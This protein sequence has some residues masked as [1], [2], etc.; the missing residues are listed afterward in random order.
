M[1]RANHVADTIK[2]ALKHVV[3]L[4]K[5][6][7]TYLPPILSDLVDHIVTTSNHVVANGDNNAPE[8]E[9]EEEDDEYDDDT[10]QTA[11]LSTKT[12]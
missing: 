1:D 2:L 10:M 9:K 8:Q 4:K 6:N 11:R 12:R 7:T 3:D 5:S